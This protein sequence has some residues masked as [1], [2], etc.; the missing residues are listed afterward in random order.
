LFVNRAAMDRYILPAVGKLP[1][2]QVDAATLDAFYAHLRTRGGKDGR[3]LKAS[4]VHEVHAVLSGALKQA[5]VW[6]WVGH[7]PAK[8][9]TAPSVQ[10]A[11]VQPPQAEDA[12]RLLSAAMAEDPE[13]GLFLPSPSCSVPAAASCARCAGLTSTSTGARC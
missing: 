10:K 4:T 11:D 6:G 8:L 3:P 9:A 13:L 1:V 5:V 2:R 7:N 12:A